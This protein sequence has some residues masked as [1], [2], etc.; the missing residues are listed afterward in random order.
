M[1]PCGSGA[2]RH[3]SPGMLTRGCARHENRACFKRQPWR[4]QAAEMPNVPRRSSPDCLSESTTAAGLEKGTGE[5][6]GKSLDVNISVEL[7]PLLVCPCRC[8]D[9]GNLW[10]EFRT[11][12]HVPVSVSR[13]QMTPESSSHLVL[14]PFSTPS[15]FYLLSNRISGTA[16]SFLIHCWR[17]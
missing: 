16:R 4:R 14:L 7:G 15:P 13:I 11:I 3:H 5:T 1:V 9:W 6:V 17:A 12:A 2:T 10:V 8:N